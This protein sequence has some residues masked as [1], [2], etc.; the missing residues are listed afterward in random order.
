MRDLN[1]CISRWKI[2]RNDGIMIAQSAISPVLPGTPP[3]GVYT[4]NPRLAKQMPFGRFL[5]CARG[6]I[7]LYNEYDRR[8]NYGLY[9]D[10]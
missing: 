2:K 3:C 7:D 4:G 8:N 10:F 6:I 5:Y 9:S 1:L